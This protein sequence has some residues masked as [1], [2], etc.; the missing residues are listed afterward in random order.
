MPT[1]KQCVTCSGWLARC[2][3]EDIALTIYP[4]D[5]PKCPRCG[6]ENSRETETDA[7]PRY[8]NAPAV[9]TKIKTLF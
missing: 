5:M 4:V 6:D 1:Y 3:P 9:A 7:I 2:L 8:R